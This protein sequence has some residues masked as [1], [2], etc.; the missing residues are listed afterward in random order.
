MSEPY[1]SGLFAHQTDR[2]LRPTHVDLR[3]RV[4]G[5]AVCVRLRQRFHNRA[6]SAVA[7]TSFLPLAPRAVICG[8]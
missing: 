8:F 4:S 1:R 5:Y 6:L 2:P 3:V 7:A